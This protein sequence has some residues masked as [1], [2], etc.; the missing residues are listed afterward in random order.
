MSTQVSV[1]SKTLSL[2]SEKMHRARLRLSYVLSA[3]LVVALTSYGLDYYL[4]D[5]AHRPF[6]PK[7]HLL[8]PSGSLGL[9]LGL[10]GLAIF[11][12]IFLYP[13]RKRWPWLKRQGI[14]RHWLDFH[15]L[16]GLLAPFVI[17][18]HSSFKFRGLAGMAFWIMSAVA[19]SGVVGR[20]LYAQIPRSLSAAELS[21]QEARETQ[22][23]LTQQLATQKVV[24]SSE[25]EPLFRLPSVEIVQ[26]EPMILILCS[27][28]LIDL[29]R[30]LRIARLRLHA[31][32]RWRAVM[33]L[34]GLLPSGLSGLERVID[35]AR[36][37]ATLSKRVLFLSRSHQVF[38]LWH[39]IHR[40]FSYSFAVLAALHIMV[41]V[42]FG[43]R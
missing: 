15:I 23:Q 42:L 24:P 25:L 32:D 18:F 27:M 17:A 33:T 4:L 2:D 29:R 9:T 34:A 20:Y 28:V 8:R 12:V 10:F 38:H 11:V 40:P 19:L 21:L 41:V 1:L 3:A 36:R 31:V 16:L 22:G 37:Q 13:L 26:S 14:T 7:H 6:S 39:V 5:S 35:T 30:E 43:L